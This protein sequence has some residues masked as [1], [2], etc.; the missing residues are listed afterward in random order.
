MEIGLAPARVRKRAPRREMIHAIT[1]VSPTP[2]PGAAIKPFQCLTVSLSLTFA[3]PR[4]RIH[5]SL[6]VAPFFRLP[7]HRPR[8][9]VSPT[10]YGQIRIRCYRFTSTSCAAT[11][12][13]Q[14]SHL[15]RDI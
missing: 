5:L 4:P 15:L 9:I 3:N 1:E 12:S 6:H 2:N 11:W 14:T 8:S 13:K 7:V 10:C